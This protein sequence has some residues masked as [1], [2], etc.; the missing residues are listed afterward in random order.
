MTWFETVNISGIN[1]SRVSTIPREVPYDLNLLTFDFN[2]YFARKCQLFLYVKSQRENITSFWGRDQQTV[3]LE[4]QING[5]TFTSGVWRIEVVF[6]IQEGLSLRVIFFE[7]TFRQFFNSNYSER[8]LHQIYPHY[9]YSCSVPQGYIWQISS[10]WCLFQ[11]W[12]SLF[13]N[14][15]FRNIT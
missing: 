6:I 8:I 15:W 7:P 1:N 4:E 5:T 14:L 2:E 12:N 11:R 9:Q 3:G 13:A 10:N